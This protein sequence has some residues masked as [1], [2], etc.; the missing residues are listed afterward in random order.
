[1]NK[2]FVGELSAGAARY[3]AQKI[4]FGPMVFQCVRIAWKS[5]LLARLDAATDGLSVAE[6]ATGHELSGYAIGVL[7]ESC[8]SAG[9]VRLEQDRY[10]L[11]KIG[12]FVVH[13]RLTQVNLD[14]TNDVCYRGLFQLEESLRS[15]RPLGLATLGPWRSLYE[16]M[17]TMPEP[18]RGSWFSFDHYYSDSAFGAALPFVL[19][20]DPARLLDVGANTGKWAEACLRAAPRLSVSLVDLAPQLA[21]AR[22]RLEAAGLLARA[23]LHT[24]DLLDPDAALPG[25][26]DVVWM[27]QLLS[28]VGVPQIQSILARARAALND[29]GRLFVLDTF[30]DRQAHDAA[31]YCLINT[32]PY[33]TAIASGCG[34]MYRC[35]DYAAC[36]REARLLLTDVRDGIGLCHSLLTF[37]AA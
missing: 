12:H 24:L 16:G 10:L 37:V 9:V 32:S 34:R 13:D 5:G 3:E 19:A 33:F 22:D 11:D 8:L 30:W 6:L 21:M 23:S 29:G 25:G 15:G 28:C 31:A 4:A 17:T 35:D 36:A 7:M 2:R 1:M 26:Q 18:A 27:S 20:G 14:F